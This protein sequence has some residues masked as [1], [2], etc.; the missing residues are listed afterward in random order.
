MSLG[1]A[2]L[3]FALGQERLGA[4]IAWNALTV[5]ICSAAGPVLG[6]FILS[7]GPWPWLFLAKLP[8]GA[9]ALTA[10][11][12][13]PRVEPVRQAVDLTGILLHGVIA[14]L[15]LIAAETLPHRP[16]FAMTLGGAAI[17]LAT[18]LIKRERV[19]Q[20][21][22]WPVDLLA[23]RPFGVAVLTS[24]CCFAGQS[25]GLLA[26][27]FHLQP[28]AGQSPVR[29]GLVLTCWPLAV[30][31]TAPMASRLAQRF[32]SASL[33]AAGGAVLGSGLLLCALWPV[34][35]NVAPL[36]IGA[37]LAG[38]GF[39]LFQVPNNRTLFLTAPPARSA[40]AGGLQGTARLVGQTLG[41][42]V[43]SLLFACSPHDVA[44]RTGLAI[45]SLFA[46]VAALVSMAGY[47]G[48]ASASPG[49]RAGLD[50]CR[51]TAKENMS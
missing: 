39:G 8:I 28:G 30:A 37:A 45:A 24:I 11:R 43:M 32:S 17:A 51:Q 47:F 26:L 20:T 25:A 35:A 48:N 34:Q 33:C 1:I 2:L 22:V 42:L 14:A 3:R 41:A 16:A 31:A 49:P 6:A 36:A 46:I 15:F 21:P 27:A 40:A 7:M 10:A 23:L 38:L 44:P 9:L 4:A 5:A 50:A 19:Q 18:L 29:A 12:W 13:L